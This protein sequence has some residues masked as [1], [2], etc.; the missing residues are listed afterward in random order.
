MEN[1]DVRLFLLLARSALAKA[2]KRSDVGSLVVQI[3]QL[4]VASATA[5]RLSGCMYGEY[6][7]LWIS[8]RRGSWKRVVL[9]C[10]N[11]EELNKHYS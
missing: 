9:Q 7:R 3:H 10:I 8:S 11:V 6:L 2:A 1:R 4:L 5:E